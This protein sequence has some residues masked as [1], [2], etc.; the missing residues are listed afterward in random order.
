M[1]GGRRLLIGTRWNPSDVIGEEEAKEAAALKACRKPTRAVLFLPGRKEDGTPRFRHMGED[2]LRAILTD[3]GPSLYAGQIDLK[4]VADGVSP[5]KE[6]YFKKAFYRLDD[7]GESVWNA[8]K[9][10]VVR[11]KV[12]PEFHVAMF[13]DLAA[14]LSEKADRTAIVVRA[15][16]PRGHVYVLQAEAGRWPAGNEVLLRIFQMQR[17]WGAEY[18]GV[19]KGGFRA[20]YEGYIRNWNAENPGAPIFFHDRIKVGGGKNRRIGSDRILSLEPWAANGQIHL[21]RDQLELL[22]ELCLYP[23][24][25]HDDLADAMALAV[26]NPHRVRVPSQDEEEEELSECAA[27]LKG[28]F[29]KVKHVDQMEG[30]YD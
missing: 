30:H 14:S 21:L 19:E 27:A 13:V 22:G 25:P 8:D 4:P 1:K 5:L 15:T 18:I 23:N 9:T 3:M 12:N 7:V 17:F 28:Y 16:D 11:F 6:E 26:L 2:E 20:V 29:S 10:K 24:A